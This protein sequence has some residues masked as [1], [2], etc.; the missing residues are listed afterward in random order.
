MTD[1]MRKTV[2]VGIFCLSLTLGLWMA[3]VFSHAMAKDAASIQTLGKKMA[4]AGT[5]TIQ[6]RKGKIR[7]VST[8]TWRKAAT[9]AKSADQIKIRKK[10]WYTFCVTTKT[11][12]RKLTR[13]YFNKKT[14]QIPVNTRVKKEK[15]YYYLVP[16]SDKS[17]AVEVQGAAL[18]AGANV[19]VWSRGDAACRVWKL[20]SAGGRKYRL[21]NVNSG[22]Y[23]ACRKKSSN[24]VQ[25]RYSAKDKTQLFTLYE[26]GSGYTYIKCVGS[27]KY[28]HVDGN[29]LDCTARR[30]AKAWK[31]KWEK[32]D[33]PASCAMVTGATYPTNLELGSAFPLQGTINSRYTI[34]VLGAAVYN[35]QGKIVLQKK[36]YPNSC[37]GNLKEI[38]AAMTFGKLASGTYTYKVAVRDV[39]GTDISLINR[40]FTV[41]PIM[42][43][44]GK[45]LAY[46]SSLIARIGHQST[47]TALE[48]KACASYALA[49][50][51]A[52]LSG[53]TPSPHSYWS[54]AANVDC[55]WSKGGY[56]T[57]AY[58]SEQAV[59]QAAAAQIAAGKPCILHVT[60]NT[61]Q[62]WLA[63]IGCRNGTSST[64]TASHLIAIDPWDGK[65]ITVS[66]KYKVKSTYRLAIKS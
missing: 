3:P 48:K 40:S 61:E 5:K 30:V 19:S 29:N 66:D 43:S 27:Q 45:T 34:T 21:R 25:A 18:N 31:F 22:R 17:R 50:C 32:T 54:S 36:S 16:A 41:G 14:Y 62:H 33:C 56:T 9:I 15:G 42:S 6:Y 53:T 2:W 8:A 63:V 65:V 24:V 28:L 4:S 58:A 59:L 35:R 1:N 13:L 12:K 44:G 10:G 38:D 51:N 11:G 7:S 20:E 49:Y 46:D 64:L 55:V 26:A 52:I 57:R 23:M 47:G 60:G 37:F 39:T